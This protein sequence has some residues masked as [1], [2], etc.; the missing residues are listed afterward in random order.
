MKKTLFSLLAIALAATACNN[1][2]I[3]YT[4]KDIRVKTTI[5]GSLTRTGTAEG[6]GTVFLDGDQIIFYAWD[7][8]PSENNEPWIKDVVL[9]KGASDVWTPS[10]KIY[11]KTAKT[12]HSF[13][14]VYPVGAIDNTQGLE[15][16]TYSFIKDT[17]TDSYSEFTEDLLRAYITGQLM[18]ESNNYS[19]TLPFS[20]AFAMLRVNMNFRNQWEQTPEVE[21]VEANLA[22][23]ASIDYYT[24]EVTPSTTTRGRLLHETTAAND[25]KKSFFIVAAPNDKGFNKIVITID[26]KTFTYNYNPSSLANSSVDDAAD[27]Q[28]ITLKQ[29]YI[30]TINLVVGRNNINLDFS[31]TEGASGITID[32]WSAGTTHNGDAFGDEE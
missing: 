7:G 2:G 24:G 30:T 15:N 18:D 21:S 6:G 10:T 23:T 4:A 13:I 32:T 14:G 22:N 28:S 20:H 29:G 27:N 5:L 1:D 12:R 26:G 17:R 8:T 19:I 31:G 11:W 25:F 3:E 16:Q 9:T